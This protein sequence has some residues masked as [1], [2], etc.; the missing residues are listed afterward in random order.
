MS[1]HHGSDRNPFSGNGERVYTNQNKST[2]NL[3]RTLKILFKIGNVFVCVY[4]RLWY[5]AVKYGK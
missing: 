5:S 2:K 3:V 1:E 4:V